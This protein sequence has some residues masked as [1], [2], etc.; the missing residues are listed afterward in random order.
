M[1]AST[2]SFVALIAV[3]ALGVGAGVGGLSYF[4]KQ[5]RERR[6]EQAMPA[7]TSYRV[8]ARGRL[9]PAGGI[10]E[11]AAPGPD[12][13]KK[14][15]IAENAEVTPGKELAVL[16]SY[17][18]R[19][20]EHDTAKTQ[21][22]EAEERLKQ[23][24]AH[25]NAQLKETDARIRQLE[26]QGPLDVQMQE[27]R[28]QLLDRQRTHAETLLARM[29]KAGSY[30]QQEL[31][32]QELFRLQAEQEASAAR[33]A[34]T[35]INEANSASLEA[36]RVQR[37]SGEIGILRAQ[38]EVPLESLRK[39]VDLA[40]ER[41]KLA[42]IRSPIAGRVLKVLASEGEMVGVQPIVQLA[43]TREMSV[44]AEVYETDVKSVRD[45]VRSGKPVEA[46]V[47]LRFLGPSGSSKFRGKVT[48]VG[49]MVMKNTAFTVDPRQD[50]DRRVVEVR[51]RLDDAFHAEAAEF[52]NMT[53]DVTIFDPDA[54]NAAAG[55]K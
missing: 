52:V 46:E 14:L 55:E 36:V 42:I 11:L 41:M 27:A 54:P 15:H 53:V 17:D 23:T 9:E 24:L 30:A 37:R 47:E 16:A 12:V 29:R 34:L 2:R 32:Q 33:S 22:R 44:M 35:K 1:F 10:L 26:V 6:G 19:K 8:S 3:F 5:P 4:S 40:A 43:E 50:V 7:A 20:I 25:L 13:V 51:I 45:W 48:Q 38:S 49:R 21:V 31:D 18:I 28:I 39:T